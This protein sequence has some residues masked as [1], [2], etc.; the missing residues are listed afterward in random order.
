M[1]SVHVK[2]QLLLPIKKTRSTLIGAIKCKISVSG[3]HKCIMPTS[4]INNC[5]LPALDACKNY[6]AC[7]C[8]QWMCNAKHNV[9]FCFEE[10]PAMG[11]LGDPLITNRQSLSEIL[12]Q[13]IFQCHCNQCSL[14]MRTQGLIVS[15]LNA[16]P[17][18]P[19]EKSNHYL[20]QHAYIL[21]IHS[22]KH[23]MLHLKLT[24]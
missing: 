2:Y 5:I 1:L 19:S 15:D 7:I 6:N 18:L 23:V 4:S 22:I 21:K 20:H 11:A 17:Q 16:T 14:S 3:A 13:N 9:H 10:L 12:M 8:C 24:I